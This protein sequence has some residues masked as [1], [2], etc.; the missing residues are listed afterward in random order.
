MKPADNGKG[1]RPRKVD[2]TTYD[3]NYDRI[4]GKGSM[5][6]ISNEELNK[7]IVF[8]YSEGYGDGNRDGYHA[9]GDVDANWD[10]SFTKERLGLLLH[11]CE[12][13]K[14]RCDIGKMKGGAC[15]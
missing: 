11:K 10:E 2:K 1:D 9:V 7:M 3:K 13:C 4:F 12:A 6:Q 5:M 15:Q 8:A 14:G